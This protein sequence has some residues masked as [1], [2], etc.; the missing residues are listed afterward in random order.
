MNVGDIVGYDCIDDGE[1]FGVILETGI[2]HERPSVL[3]LWS[4][5][6]GQSDW[7][8]EDAVWHYEDR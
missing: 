5:R 2:I 7:V 4:D 8:D 3:I 1:V 6:Y